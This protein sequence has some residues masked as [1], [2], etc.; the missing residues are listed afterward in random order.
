MA[1]SYQTISGLW[2]KKTKD[3]R[4][5]LSA[6]FTPSVRQQLLAALESAEG[7][8]AEIVVFPVKQRKS[9][10]SPTHTL[11]LSM[12]READHAEA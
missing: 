10:K 9:D 7:F 2:E 5:L 8:E 12:S 1:N 6:K 11:F 3:G 4:V